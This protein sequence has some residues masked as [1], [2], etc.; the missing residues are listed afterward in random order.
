M[1]E[2][3]P[4]ITIEATPPPRRL[5]ALRLLRLGRT[6][7]SRLLEAA[8]I[9][10]I[11]MRGLFH[12][13]RAQHFVGA[14]WG[15]IV[16]GRTAFCWPACIAPGEPEDTAS[17]LQS[18]VDRHLDAAGVVMAQAVLPLRDLTNALRLTRAGYHHLADLNYLVS[19]LDTSPH[20]MPQTELQFTPSTRGET[21]RWERLIDH[22]YRDT[23]D[24]SDLDGVR[25][26]PDVM[27]GYLRTGV[28]RPEWWVFAQHGGQDVGCVLLADHPEHDQ[29]E[30]MYMGVVPEVRGRGWGLELARFAQWIVRR[31]GRARLVLA[32][33][34][35]N[36]PAQNV[37]K[38]AGFDV[39]DQR[40][41]FVRE[42][43]PTRDPANVKQR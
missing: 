27:N 21:R 23:L 9:G 1:P 3:R 40:S 17:Q 12:A 33:D 41:V 26:T 43:K 18:A 32:V 39:W 16:P 4:E 11:D 37:Y 13:R 36:W 8:Q 15:Q 42:A 14:A 6:R 30:L 5:E 24:C 20:E 29:A 25:G 10:Q 22:T 35:A 2:Q 19:M 34:D 38:S 31:A 28:Y 7:V